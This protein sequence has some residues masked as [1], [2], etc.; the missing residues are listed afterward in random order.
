MRNGQRWHV[1]AVDEH[2]EHPGSPPRRLEDG[3]R[4]AFSGD[5]LAEHISHGYAVTVHSAQGVTA[6]TTHVDA[7]DRWGNLFAATPSGGWIGS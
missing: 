4:T 3:A 2:P 6:D 7:V 1:I 5:Y